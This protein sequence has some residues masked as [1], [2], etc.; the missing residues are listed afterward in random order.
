MSSIKLS[1][2][3]SFLLCSLLRKLF[4][5]TIPPVNVHSH[6]SGH[7]VLRSH[8]LYINSNIVFPLFRPSTF[9]PFLSNIMDLICCTVTPLLT[10]I[11]NLNFYTLTKRSSKNNP[12]TNLSFSTN[13][14]LYF[15]LRRLHLPSIKKKK[16]KNETHKTPTTDDL[17]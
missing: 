17:I 1:T 15:S 2:I 10:S 13:I 3:T 5:F 9:H 12:I 7:R 11:L 6:F 16:R 4:L 14:Q 8:S